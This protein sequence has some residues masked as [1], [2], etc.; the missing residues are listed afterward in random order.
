MSNAKLANSDVRSEMKAA[1]VTLWQI[2]DSLKV[3]EMTI[4]R[5]FR[6]EKNEAEK[7]EMLTIIKQIAEQNKGA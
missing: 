6:R 1:G 3:C 5:K 2:A 7:D 4:T